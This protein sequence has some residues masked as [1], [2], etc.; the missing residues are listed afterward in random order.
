MIDEF[1]IEHKRGGAL[2]HV[3]NRRSTMDDRRWTMDDRRW[4]I[5]EA[6]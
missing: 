6:G 3:N 1:K 5:D 2:R 4:T